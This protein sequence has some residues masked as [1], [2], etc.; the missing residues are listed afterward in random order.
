MSVLGYRVVVAPRAVQPDLPLGH[1]DV[2]WDTLPHA[3]QT[4][5]L[6]RWC[7]LLDAVIT[8]AAPGAMTQDDDGASEETRP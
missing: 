6:A 5:V 8:G 2:H 3:V 1:S 4:E 7:E